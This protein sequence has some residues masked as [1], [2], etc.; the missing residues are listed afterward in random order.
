[1]LG[2]QPADGLYFIHTQGVAI[3]LNY[4]ALSALFDITK[5]VISQIA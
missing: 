4:V 2:L 5:N 3:G 1:M